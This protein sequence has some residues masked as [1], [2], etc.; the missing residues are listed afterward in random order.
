[1]E[2]ARRES[3]R[4]ALEPL[5]G[6][7]QSQAGEQYREYAGPDGYRLDESKSAFLARHG[8]GPGPADPFKMPYYLLLAAGPESIPYEFEWQLSV[9]YAV[10]RIDFGD[11]LEAYANY[12]RS[13][14]AAETGKV[15]RRQRAVFFAVENP[16]D[17]STY[18]SANGLVKPLAATL[19]REQA[20]WEVEVVHG[21][22]ATKAR[23]LQLLG[24]DDTPALLLT[25][26]HGLGFPQGDPRQLPRQGALL[27]QDW[28][29]PRQWQEAIPDDFY[30][31]A[32][33]IGPDAQPQGLIAFHYASYSAGTPKLDRFAKEALK[34]QAEIAP[35]AFVARLP[36]RLLG[37]P[38]GGALA[39]VGPVDR[40]WGFS[41]T[42]EGLGVQRAVFESSL[43]R[44]M[45]GHP[46]GSAQESFS[47]RYAELAT[48]LTRELMDRQ[49]GG[50]PDYRTLAGMWTA[51]NDRSLFIIGDPAV[52]LPVGSSF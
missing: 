4:S 38:N 14:V 15:Q 10:G 2:A 41:L 18:L 40:A 50:Q 20:D 32:G 36:Q 28:P 42:W 48:T 1:M 52:R 16:D 35:H 12:A 17:L 30:L 47:M 5:L 45:Q 31:A 33:D 29:G 46:L 24:G 6:L 25:A 43:M 7:R 22:E 39:V 27:C 37:H 21:E 9:E 51:S 34:A 11:D 44:L 26:S 19:A 8:V 13:V 23:L 3:I 49:F